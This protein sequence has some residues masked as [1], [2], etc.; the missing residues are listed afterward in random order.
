[1]F[2]SL[3]GLIIPATRQNAG[4]LGM[5]LPSGGVNEP[6]GTA[7]ATVI[8]APDSASLARP[9]QSAALSVPPAAAKMMAAARCNRRLSSNPTTSSQLRSILVR[10]S[11]L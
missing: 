9:A 8:V 1:M 11:Q 3:V 2:E 7:S 10:I 5:G 4:R 6:A